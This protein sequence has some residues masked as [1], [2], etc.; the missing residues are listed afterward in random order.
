[1]SPNP[2]RSAKK[3]TKT[4]TGAARK[5]AR[6]VEPSRL[7]KGFVKLLPLS[8]RTKIRL[9]FAQLWAKFKTWRLRR[10]ARNV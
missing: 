5:G 1:M 2:T 9:F 4:T 7:T 6:T 10:R 8:L 3:A